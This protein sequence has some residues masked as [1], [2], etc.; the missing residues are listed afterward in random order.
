MQVEIIPSLVDNYAYLVVAPGGEAAIVDPA[1]A[2][3]V[4][5]ALRRHRVR[6]AAIWN[7]HHHSDHTGGNTELLAALPN[8]EVHGHRRDRGRIQGQ[9][10]FHEDGDEIHLGSLSGRVIHNPGHTLGAVTY[11]IED[12]AFTGDTLFS[13]GCGRIFEGDAPMMFASLAKLAALPPETRVYPGHEYTQANL[14]FALAV[15]PGNSAAR[16][17]KREVDDRRTR[18]QPTVPSTIGKEKEVNPFLRALHLAVERGAATA[19]EG[20]A[21]LRRQKDHF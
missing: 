13:A 16:E 15:D 12:A 19:L 5:A 2:T 17:L 11:L 18:G 3:P 4:W 10:V 8:L 1:E 20:F 21:A 14:A 6:L 7:T 9:T